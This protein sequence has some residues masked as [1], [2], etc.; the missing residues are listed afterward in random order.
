[1]AGIAAMQRVF[2][3]VAAPKIIYKQ[4]QSVPFLKYIGGNIEYQ[5]IEGA[6]KVYWN[7]V[8]GGGNARASKSSM[9]QSIS[10][11]F[12]RNSQLE[13]GVYYVQARSVLAD[14]ED[15]RASK[16]GL[17]LQA[18]QNAAAQS[19]MAQA[20]HRGTLFG[21]NGASGEGLV[22]ASGVGANTLPADSQGNA[23]VAEYLADE[24]F[25]YLL[26]RIQ[27]AEGATRNMAKV[28][29]MAM[30]VAIY[31]SV[32]NTKIVK[33]TAYANAGGTRTIGQAINETRRATGQPEIDF[34]CDDSLAGKGASGK[35]LIILGLPNIRQLGVIG[36][37]TNAFG[38]GPNADE[39]Q[40][41]MIFQSAD[42]IRKTAPI[43]TDAMASTYK[44]VMTPAVVKRRE[45]LYLISASAV[46][47]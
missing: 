3:H 24:L 16:M 21:F 10:E 36:M 2:P 42:L 38:N 23:G 17:P 46:N 32:V 37:D 5:D 41:G 47:P 26:N 4:A 12:V 44:M 22:N 7:V 14:D 13:T 43:G 45:G 15:A 8:S 28:T 30:P 6:E 18:L 20:M 39:S 19:V 31:N 1:M 40:L 25:D 33:L 9:S 11:V 35:D 29:Y 34:I 27:V